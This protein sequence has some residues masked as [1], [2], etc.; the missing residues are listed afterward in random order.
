MYLTAHRVKDR[1]GRADINAFLYLHNKHELPASVWDSPDVVFIAEKAPGTLV[2]SVNAIPP[3]N[4]SVVSYLDVVARNGTSHDVLQT[5]LM[6]IRSSLARDPSQSVWTG[7]PVG[8]RFSLNRGLVGGEGEEFSCLMNAALNVFSVGENLVLSSDVPLTILLTTDADG[9]VFALDEESTQRVLRQ[10][11]HPFTPRG[12]LVIKHQDRL[13]FE[14]IYGDL[15]QHVATMLTELAPDKIAGLGGVRIVKE[16][17]A[18]IVRE[19]LVA[20]S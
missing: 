9:A 7:Q 1:D 16:G 2:K 6:D 11:E 17:S 12:R 18:E 5:A 4:N 3:G 8:V 20:P 13:A 14:N 15:I 10:H 19:Y